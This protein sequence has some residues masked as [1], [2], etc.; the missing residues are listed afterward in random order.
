MGGVGGLDFGSAF[1]LQ[2]HPK[3]F[4][5]FRWFLWG[6]LD[7]EDFQTDESNRHLLLLIYVSHIGC[8]HHSFDIHFSMIQTIWRN[9][10]YL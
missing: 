4:W 7:F 9:S 6:S 1:K 2:S 8:Y 10:S 5:L 3:S